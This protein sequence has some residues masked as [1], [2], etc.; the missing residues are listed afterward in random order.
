MNL[1]GLILILLLCC[2]VPA[3]LYAIE[4][5]VIS[6]FTG[7][8]VQL[9][10]FSKSRG[11]YTEAFSVTLQ[12]ADPDAKIYYTT[13]GIRPSAQKG[14]LYQN[15]IWIQTTTPLSAVAVKNGM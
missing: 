4:K 3:Q 2:F 14:I 9:P 1:K 13:N 5:L 8:K 12:T 10:V 6:E 15:P 11:Y 7:S